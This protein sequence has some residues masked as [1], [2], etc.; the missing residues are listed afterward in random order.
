MHYATPDTV[1][2]STTNVSG[3]LYGPKP[4]AGKRF[5]RKPD[6]LCSPFKYGVMIRPPPI[7][8]ASLNLF[9]RL[10]AD[11]S[12]YRSTTVMQF[13]TT[14]LTGAFIAKSFADDALPDSVFMSCFVKC[15]QYDDFW[16]RP[17][18]F[19][20]QYSSIQKFRAILNIEWTKRDTSEPRYS[21]FAAVSALQRC[22]PFTILKNTKMIL[23]PVLH[24][25]HWSVYCINF[26]QSRIDVLDSMDYDSNNYHSWDMFHSDMGAKIMNRLSDALSEAAPHKFKSFKNWRHV[27]VQ[28]PIHKNPSDSLFFAMKFLEYYDGEG[29]GSLKT[30][31]D[32]AGS[33]ELRAE[34]LYYITF[35]SENNVATL[36][37]DLI[38]FRQTDLQPFFY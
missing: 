32:T 33:K 1:F 15:L 18:C 22:L 30:N 9:A 38:Q 21:Q 28:V 16:I 25:Y 24:H 14:H 2:A 26:D 17:E 27:Q 23:L 12:I 7:V 13:G 35:H 34:M 11:D 10:C 31:L 8:D 37:D 3:S 29:H 6:K 20:Y 36:P 5:T 19:G 4:R